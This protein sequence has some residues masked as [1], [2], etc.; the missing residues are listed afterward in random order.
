MRWPWS[1]PR[2]YRASYTDLV[3]QAAQAAAAGPAARHA[4]QTG[5]LEACA[6]QWA[7]ALAAALVTP[8]TVATAAVTPDTLADI[9]RRLI[10]TGDS[11][12][13]I[14]VGPAGVRLLPASQWEVRGGPDPA[15]WWYRVSLAGPD[16]TATRPVPAAGVVHLRWATAAHAPW[17]GIGP[18]QWAIQTGRLSGELE[19]A[20]ADEAAGPRGHVLP[21]PEGQREATDDDDDDDDPLAAIRADLVK[22]KGGLALVETMASGYGDRGGRPDADW[23]PRRIGANPPDALDAI[24]TGAALAVYA[25]CGVPPSLVTLPADGT[26]Q[27]EAWRRF[28]HGSV[29]P[30]ARLVQTELRA[31]LDTPDLSLDLGSLY[32]ADVTGRARAWR[33]LVGKDTTMPDADA[34]RVVGF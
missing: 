8:A 1:R 5:A 34:R 14:D 12:H 15:S 17:R 20:L 21:A 19:A 23:K 32:A 10:R 6:G 27:R 25:A 30:V 9:G 4:L 29:S 3:I 7:R 18:I 33:S 11:L 22:L 2:E 16:G 13:V 31:K 24:R 28:L 26:G